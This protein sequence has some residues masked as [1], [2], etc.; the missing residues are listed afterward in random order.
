MSGTVHTHAHV[1]I[2]GVQGSERVLRVVATYVRM[3]KRQ[4]SYD[5]SFKL[6]TVKFVEEKQLHVSFT[7]F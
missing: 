5:L 4:A 3:S 6:K 1:Q 2:V 7:K